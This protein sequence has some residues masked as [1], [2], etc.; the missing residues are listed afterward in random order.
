MNCVPTFPIYFHMSMSCSTFCYSV[1]SKCYYNPYFFCLT[2]W[3]IF[4]SRFNAPHNLRAIALGDAP[5]DT[6]LTVLSGR[7]EEVEL[8]IVVC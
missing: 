7:N 4:E 1:Y 5:L 2:D 6:V 8:S 3:E